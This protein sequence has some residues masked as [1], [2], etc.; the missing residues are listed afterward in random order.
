[1]T[2]T[3]TEKKVQLKKALPIYGGGKLG[4]GSEIIVTEEWESIPP[5]VRGR[6]I[7]DPAG[8]RWLVTEEDLEYALGAH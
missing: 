2:K 4:V 3:K 5:H 7:L 8:Q 6:V 1:M